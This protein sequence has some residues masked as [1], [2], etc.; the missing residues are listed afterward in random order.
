MQQ[1]CRAVERH[2]RPD[3]PVPAE[4]E[5]VDPHQSA[6]PVTLDLDFGANTTFDE[7]DLDEYTDSGTNPRVQTF[8]LRR[9][10][11]ATGAWVTFA[12][13]A[14]GI[15]HD[16]AVTGF[17]SITTTRLQLALTSKIATEVYTPT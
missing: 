8:D 9:W 7:V 12:S 1:R 16:L 2:L 10:D 15:G 5:S 4:Q 3:L 17:G 14:D 13:R 6:Y 11:A